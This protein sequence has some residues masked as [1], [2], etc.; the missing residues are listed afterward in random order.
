M[1]MEKIMQ[2]VTKQESLPFLSKEVEE[3]FYFLEVGYPEMDDHIK[4]L[5][6]RLPE[7]FDI[8]DIE[9]EVI[10][11][12]FNYGPKD[13]YKPSFHLSL[14]KGKMR[15]DIDTRSRN[16]Y[17][18]FIN[19]YYEVCF[20]ADMPKASIGIKRIGEETWNWGQRGSGKV[21]IDGVTVYGDSY[22]FSPIE[23][24]YKF[25]LLEG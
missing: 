3:F 4:V 23:W 14:E 2:Y 15:I 1:K 22:D 24:G 11:G 13:D 25:T 10:E 12:G 21:T 9:R 20:I 6:E 17:I 16:V 18:N 8:E 19:S 7:S 5:A